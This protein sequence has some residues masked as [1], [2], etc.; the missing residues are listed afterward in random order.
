MT[1]PTTRP[2]KPPPLSL[3]AAIHDAKLF[4]PWFRKKAT[5]G[6]W[7]AFISALFALPMTPEQ[8]AIYRSCTARVTPPATPF[9][10][11]W[12][13]VGRRG[14]K[15][16]VLAL[17]AVWLAC[18]HK[19]QQFLQ[20]GE[21]ASI[22]IIAADRRQARNIFRYVS[23]L[24]HNVPMLRKL[25]ER[26]TADAFDLTN[27]VTIEIH[28]TSFKSVR[29]Y[30]VV[31]ALCDETSFWRSED[32]ANPDTEII[33]AL[34]PA[35]ATIPN[36]KLL[37]ASSPY[38]K[39]GV[40]WEAYKKHFGEDSSRKLV[41]Q[42]ETR[43]MNPSVPQSFIDQAYEDDN[44]SAS[45]EYGALFRSDIASF[46]SR[47]S[48]DAAIQPGALELPPSSN[49]RYVAFVDPSG[50]SADSM[51]L[52]IAHRDPKENIGV[53]DAIREV[54]P[55]FAPNLVVEQFAA[56]L[57]SYRV[58]KVTGDRYGGIWVETAFKK[59]GISYEASERS[60]SQIYGEFLPLINS[61][62][63]E[64]LD[65]KRLVSQLTNLERRTARGGKDTIDHPQGPGQHDD[66]ANAA[67]GA[68][69]LAAGTPSKAESF[70]AWAHVNL[71]S[72]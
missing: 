45:A 69:V 13:I 20:P 37:V 26:Q 39:K 44:A 8:L 28:V 10:E 16:F 50:G 36:A 5:W 49:L 34:R 60:K 30:T 47:E 70:S 62:R 24:I 56:L 27:S 63:V 46:V 22:I 72:F 48:V 71:N 11:A 31:A 7:L 51:T 21:R 32:S 68:L 43:M 53:L 57:K 41:W 42:A 9:N 4:A 35:M 15:S 66:I 23:G 40:V 61:G 25:I 1:R 3:L 29:G 12:L 55:T 67:A 18:F 54:K 59:A 33:N 52:A 6:A 38:A 2:A 17:I 65:H 58:R 64:L 14:G 19:Y